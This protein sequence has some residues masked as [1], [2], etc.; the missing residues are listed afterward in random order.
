[1]S[2][3]GRRSAGSSVVSTTVA[4]PHEWLLEVVGGIFQKAG[5]S[6]GAAGSIADALVDA[7]VRG[8]SSHGVM[9][10]PIYVERVQRGAVSLRETFETVVDDGAV[11][12]LDAEHGMGQLSGRLAMDMAVDRA[13]SFGV[14][15]VAVRRAHHFGAAGRYALQAAARRCI[16][17]ACSNTTPL[18]PA[19]GGA[20]RIVGNNPIA[21]AAPVAGAQPLLVDMALS[22]V[23]LNRI[24]LAEQAGQPIPDTWA[25]DAR[26]VPT[27]DPGAAI[28]G[29]LLPAGGYKGFGLAL[30]VEVLTGMLSGGGWPVRSVYRDRDLPND[31]SHFFLALDVAHFMDPDIFER[32]TADLAHQ[33]RTSPAAPGEG[34]VHAPGDGRSERL[35]RPQKQG[36][37]VGRAVVDELLECAQRLGLQVSPPRTG[38]GD[39]RA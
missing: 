30:M 3:S 4:V 27:T 14:G 10:T 19:P 9:L 24:R 16:G 5:F 31:C 8:I 37:E 6:A 21:I 17:V 2:G 25:T 7:D 20:A 33:V 13:R 34:P 32:Q 12:V 22:A 39:A 38:A 15:A 29:M 23:A 18:M 26:G 36:V 28:E 35:R 11:A 1:M